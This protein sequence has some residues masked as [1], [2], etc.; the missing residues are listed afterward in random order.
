MRLFQLALLA[1]EIAELADDGLNS[2]SNYGRTEVSMEPRAFNE[3][4]PA[5]WSD[6]APFMSSTG[7]LCVR[8]H[9]R[10]DGVE[11]STVM[12]VANV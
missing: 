5:C 6:D 2:I 4:F 12:E 7:K 9:I 3:M 11:Y 1:K 8:R 10:I